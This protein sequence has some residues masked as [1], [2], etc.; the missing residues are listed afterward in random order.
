MNPV[1][2]PNYRI[3][4][5]DL[6]YELARFPG[7]PT[8]SSPGEHYGHALSFFDATIDEGEKRGIAVKDRLDAQGAMWVI[9]GGGARGPYGLSADEWSKFEEFVEIPSAIRKEQAQKVARAPQ[10]KKRPTNRMCPLCGHD[11]EVRL[12]GPEGDQWRFECSG[13]SHSEPYSFLRS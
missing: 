13:D 1:R 2:W 7:I 6:A 3:T 5:L 12:V 9:A 11:D 4:A 8:K 10:Q